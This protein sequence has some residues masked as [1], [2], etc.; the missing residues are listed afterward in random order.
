MN[1]CWKLPDFPHLGRDSSAFVPLAGIS[2]TGEEVQPDGGEDPDFR[3][4]QAYATPASPDEILP[5]SPLSRFSILVV[6]L[7]HLIDRNPNLKV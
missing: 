6:Q 3:D 5:I 1:L 4:W 2:Q 7:K